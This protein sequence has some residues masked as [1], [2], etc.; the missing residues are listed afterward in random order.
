MTQIKMTEERA[1]AILAAYQTGDFSIE[2]GDFTPGGEPA[3][4]VL[5]RAADAAEAYLDSMGR[6]H[7]GNES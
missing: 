1:R 2:V 7:G 5:E 3:E 6:P 4:E